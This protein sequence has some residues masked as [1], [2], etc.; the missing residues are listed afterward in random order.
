[1][2][3]LETQHKKELEVLKTELREYMKIK[4]KLWGKIENLM[5]TDADFEYIGEE[6][7][8]LLNKEFLFD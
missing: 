1:M 7:V 8:D 2:E 6:T 3:L 5:V 4:N